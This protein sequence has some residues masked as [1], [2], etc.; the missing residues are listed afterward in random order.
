M[1]DDEWVINSKKVVKVDVRGAEASKLPPDV[2]VK[3]LHDGGVL[4]ENDS[5]NDHA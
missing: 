1:P 4:K 3:A 2:F 5:R